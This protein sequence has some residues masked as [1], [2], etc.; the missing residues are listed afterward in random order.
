MTAIGLGQEDCDREVNFERVKDEMWKDL[1]VLAGQR[2]GL[3]FQHL[4]ENI[5]GRH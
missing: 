1:A 3:S 2:D 4:A 5:L